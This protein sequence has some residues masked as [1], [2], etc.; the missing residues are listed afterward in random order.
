MKKH[1]NNSIK[2]TSKSTLGLAL[3]LCL[4]ALGL[5]AQDDLTTDGNLHTI[6]YSGKYVD[7]KIPTTGTYNAIYLKATG[8]DGGDATKVSPDGGNG[9]TVEGYLWVGTNNST[10]P[11]GTTVRFIVGQM[12]QSATD[13]GGGG[14]GTAIA[15]KKNDVWQ[16]VS[17]AGGGGG[18]GLDTDG[19]E[20]TTLTSG[21]NGI[22]TNDLFEDKYMRNAGENGYGGTSGN[23]AGSGGGYLG[24]G[25]GITSSNDGSTYTGGAQGNT[26]QD[27]PTG[28]AGGKGGDKDASGVNRANGGFGYGGGGAGTRSTSSDHGGGGGGGYSGGGA[29]ENNGGGGGGGSFA[30]PSLLKSISIKGHGS[31]PQ[32]TDG[33]IYY[34]FV[35][36][37]A[38]HFHA[39]ANMGYCI[40][41]ESGSTTNGK[42]LKL[43]DCSSTWQNL[44]WTVE[45]FEIS[46]VNNPGK[47]LDLKNNDQANGTN[48]QLWDCNQS[49]A[50]KW[51]YDGVSTLIRNAA[52]VDKCVNL[53]WDASQNITNVELASCD[54]NSQ[55]QQFFLETATTPIL[56]NK[57]GAIRTAQAMGMC[58]DALNN[59][60][61]DGN[62]I[63]LYT[64]ESNSVAQTW[65]FDGTAIKLNDDQN[66]C[67]DLK[68]MDT[69]NGS[70]I[71]L[72]ECNG[73]DAQQWIYD[74][75]SQSIRS[76]VDSSKCIDVVNGINN[77]G[78]NIQLYD[79]NYG[80]AQKFTIDQ[81]LPL[82]TYTFFWCSSSAETVPVDY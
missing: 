81:L 49:D 59:S 26:D 52:D 15:I 60:R 57:V 78:T 70:N 32:P 48:I 12:G 17:V 9:A 55:S 35:N 37:E 13:Y 34:Q 76:K 44:A 29:G 71:Q 24:A 66:K 40:A 41:T 45:G 56:D 75:S 14:G 61:V 22:A 63:Q 6:G 11:A 31:A 19:R 27:E 64:C 21:S 10:L 25:K 65:F 4:F 20:G 5:S 33:S 79:C 43:V 39:A 46:L 16:I 80:S 18:A 74:G 2:T 62:N 77:D 1:R 51:I 67:L 38:G 72:W 50:Q 73:T 47:C 3:M 42:N 8:G 69:S 68:N 36:F 7:Y 54:A 23:T 53:A 28:G 82:L 30:D 58:F